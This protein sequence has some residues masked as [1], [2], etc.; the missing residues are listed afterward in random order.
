MDKLHAI[1]T[2]YGDQACLC[3]M[4]WPLPSKSLEGYWITLADN[5]LGGLKPPLLSR[6]ASDLSF[7]I[8][9]STLL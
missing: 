5:S 1:L 3:V 4:L 6:L 8:R 2:S 7:V 9:W